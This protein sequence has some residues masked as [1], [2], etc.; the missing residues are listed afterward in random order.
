[1]MNENKQWRDKHVIVLIKIGNVYNIDTQREEFNCSMMFVH[2]LIV[3]FTNWRR[4]FH[5][6]DYCWWSIDISHA[7]THFRSHISQSYLLPFHLPSHVNNN[8]HMYRH[9]FQVSIAQLFISIVINATS[10]LVN[11]IHSQWFGAHQP[12]AIR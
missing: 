4:L 5:H 11:L 12:S 7:P 2:W 9:W 8:V 3:I 1:M 10:Q 6:P